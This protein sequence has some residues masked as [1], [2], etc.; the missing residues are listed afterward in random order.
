MNLFDGKFLLVIFY[1]ILIF[2]IVQIKG[3]EKV[4]TYRTV[5][6]KGLQ[7]VGGAVGGAV[8]DIKGIVNDITGVDAPEN[9]TGFGDLLNKFS[10]AFR[11]IY[12]GIL[13]TF[14]I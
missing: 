1:V 11:A 14:T 2:G 5:F 9:K 10:S 12:P 7:G 8:G 3:D 13:R 6:E 4:P